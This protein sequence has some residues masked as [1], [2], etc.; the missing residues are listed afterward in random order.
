MF[1]RQIS[2]ADKYVIVW[3]TR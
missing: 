1:L 3:D 2:K